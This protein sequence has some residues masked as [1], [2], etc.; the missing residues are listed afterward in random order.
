MFV[1]RHSPR[2]TPHYA[3]IKRHARE[4]YALVAERV[5][6]AIV[7]QQLSLLGLNRIE[8]GESGRKSTDGPRI[9]LLGEDLEKTHRI[10]G[11]QPLQ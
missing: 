8:N 10:G 5:N 11:L 1:A 3:L 4:T 9:L 7:M 2:R 6:I